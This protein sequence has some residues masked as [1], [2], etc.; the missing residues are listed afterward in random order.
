MSVLANTTILSNFASVDRLD[1]LHALW[2]DL[3]VAW[4]VYEELRRGV[5]EGYAFL[6]R[7]DTSLWQSERW[8]HLVAP[9]DNQELML[10]NQLLNH[11]HQGEAMSLA[12]AVSRSWRFLTDD[13]AARRHAAQLGVE[14][15]GTI[16]ALVLL[17]RRD[18]LLLSDANTMLAGMK[19][20]ARYHTPI[21][22][23]SLLVRVE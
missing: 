5:E 9:Q 6:S 19:E 15:G 18:H 1:L 3:Y 21:E 20:Q 13:R 23:L 2:D 10:F 14:V 22:D 8:L 4:S 11:M 7:V 12:I 16:G 17:V